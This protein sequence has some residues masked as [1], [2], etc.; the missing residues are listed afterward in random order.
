MHEAV[1]AA[2]EIESGCT[3]HYVNE[4]Y[5]DGAPLL[6]ARCPVLPDD[7]PDKLAARVLELEHQTYPAALVK[8]IHD[9][10]C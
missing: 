7:T 6:Q 5:D 8:A 9:K 2:G 1:I 3:V 10:G 4:V